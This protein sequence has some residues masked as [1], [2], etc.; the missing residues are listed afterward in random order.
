MS[1]RPHARLLLTCAGLVLALGATVDVPPAALAADCNHTIFDGAGYKYD[2][3][4]EFLNPG[5]M[6]PAPIDVYGA[7]RDG[8]SNG[9]A[10]SPP[11]PVRT[12]DAWSGWGGIFVLSPDQPPFTP[13][14]ADM[15]HGSAAACELALGGQ[16]IAFPVLP[17]KGLEVQHRWYV[18][19]G[20]L[21]GARILTVLHNPGPAPISVQLVQGDPTGQHKLGELVATVAATSDGGDNFS[22]SAVWG[23]ST[24]DTTVDHDPALAHVWDGS[25]GQ[26][27]VELASLNGGALYWVWKGITVPAGGTSAFVSYEIQAAVPGRAT[28]AEVAE[29]VAQAEAREHQPLSS[30]YIGMSAA[31]I[32]GTMNWPHPSPT[33]AIAPVRDV[34]AATPV[35]LDGGGSVGAAGL[36]QCSASYAWKAD[37][38]ATGSTTQLTRFFSPGRHSATLTVGNDCGGTAQSTQVSFQV[39]PGLRLL[40]VRP[41][42][43]IGTAAL[44]L[45][46]LGPGRL[47][48]AGKGIERQ[49]KRATKAGVYSLIVRPTGKA[50]RSL[51]RNARATVK[52][53]VTLTPAGGRPSRIAKTIVLRRVR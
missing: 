13:T 12:E 23:V 18:D 17:M 37:D 51:V 30:L 38:G 19:P 20:P 31:E 29:A 2:F 6:P 42:R 9:P 36:P 7:P 45:R 48:L 49:A 34:N 50:L 11:G 8:G 24:D 15:Y 1:R 16:E 21:H 4:V 41:N 22:P 5:G 3:G 46:A 53:T 32:A 14:A 43:G 10:D 52:A 39:A 25:G 40:K 28:A 33:A 47:T 27:R 35:S 26:A 44:K